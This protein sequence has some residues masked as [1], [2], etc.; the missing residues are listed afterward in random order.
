MHARTIA[1]LRQRRKELIVTFAEIAAHEAA[2][3]YGDRAWI[4][5]APGSRGSSSSAD[6]RNWW[7]VALRRRQ[8]RAGRTRRRRGRPLRLPRSE[9]LDRVNVLLLRRRRDQPGELDRHQA[10]E[11]PA[12]QRGER[13]RP[14]PPDRCQQDA[15][16]RTRS[17]R[18]R[19]ADAA[20]LCPDRPRTAPSCRARW[21][22][23]RRS[24][25]RT[26]RRCRARRT[27]DRGPGHH[28]H[29]GRHRH[30]E[31]DAQKS[32]RSAICGART[33]TT[34][35]PTVPT[36]EA[37]TTFVRAALSALPRR[38]TPR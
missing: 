19:L 22:S 34:R 33:I 24:S 26:R 27:T 11:T 32:G 35:A 5:I 7:P 36:T 28:D 13:V 30:H 9:E 31:R 25:R 8:P 15:T 6:S 38:R 4:R 14:H 10:Q 2:G 18:R 23:T 1:A 20:T 17:C 3:L 16:E 29:E 12:Q 37:T 21:R